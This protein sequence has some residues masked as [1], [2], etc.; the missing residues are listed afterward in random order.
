MS[1]IDDTLEALPIAAGQRTSRLLVVTLGGLHAFGS[2]SIDMYL[3]A[4]PRIAQELAASMGSLEMTLSFFLAGIAFGQLT[5]GTLSDHCGRRLPMLI[6]CIIFVF[7]SVACTL[8][9]TV[10]NLIYARFVM[11]FGSSAGVVVARAVVRDM[12][13]EKDSA[14]YFTMMMIIAGLAPILAPSIGSL[15]LSFWCWRAIFGIIAAFAALCLAGICFTVPETLPEQYRARGHVGTIATTYWRLL[16]TRKFICYA[17]VLSFISA[18][19]FAYIASA[20]LLFM[21]LRGVTPGQFSIYFMFNAAGVY[22]A[23]QSNRWLLHKLEPRQIL[24]RALALNVAACGVLVV[25]TISGAGG[26]SVF[27]G[28]LFV[29]VASLG[30]IFPNAVAAAMKPV[31]EQAGS[32]S[33]LMGTLQFVFGALAAGLVG[34]MHSGSAMPAVSLI[35]VTSA[36]SGV[37]VLVGKAGG[38]GAELGIR[39]LK[40]AQ[41]V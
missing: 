16:F 23:G 35:A 31:P 32:A 8:A 7:A 17:L 3:P 24:A 28:S 20:P 14:R 11:G 19:L 2:L 33:A 38:Q 21:K 10:N 41:V 26:F 6:G 30:W 18:A 15:L 5:W 25:N 36:L 9:D 27:L 29:F 39:G 1:H 4:F 37:M 22:L 34:A 13:N 12:F 40:D